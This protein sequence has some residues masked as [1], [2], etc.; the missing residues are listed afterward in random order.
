MQT[1]DHEVFQLAAK[2]L[3]PT[4]YPAF[5][6]LA[7]SEAAK[8]LGYD[9]DVGKEHSDKFYN[10]F[11]NG[12]TPTSGSVLWS[13]IEHGIQGAY[14][15]RIWALLLMAEMCKADPTLNV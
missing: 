9:Y 13:A 10:V 8:E 4:F 14:E 5:A 7:I 3:V 2:L 11:S 1:Y 12:Q 15:Q 6:C